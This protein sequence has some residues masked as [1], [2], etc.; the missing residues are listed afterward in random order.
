MYI[1]YI[2]VVF[3]FET[4]AYTESYMIFLKFF[5]FNNVYIYIPV[6]KLSVFFERKNKNKFCLK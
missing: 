1:Y 3:Q 5:L 2:S 4:M 6:F